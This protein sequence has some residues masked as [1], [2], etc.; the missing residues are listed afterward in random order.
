[1]RIVLLAI[2][3]FLGGFIAGYLCAVIAGLLIVEYAGIFD[4][5]GALSM[6][7]I[8]MIGPAAGL[9]AGLAAAIAAAIRLRRV[10]PNPERRSG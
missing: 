2:L 7:I 1:M 4:R 9:V 10:A 5:E 8:F 6:G 3:A